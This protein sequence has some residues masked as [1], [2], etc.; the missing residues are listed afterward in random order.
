M[1]GCCCWHPFRWLAGLWGY[2]YHPGMYEG[3]Y[4]G[5]YESW[6]SMPVME[7]GEI[8][9]YIETPPEMKAAPK[10][11]PQPTPAPSKQASA[12]RGTRYVKYAAQSGQNV[13]RQSQPRESQYQP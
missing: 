6:D 10:T 7:G 4:D 3:M 12:K 2:R 1:G 9:E 8:Q 13:R 11:A 5:G